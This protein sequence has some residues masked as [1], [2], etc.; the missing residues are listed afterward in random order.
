MGHLENTKEWVVVGRFGRPH[1]LKGNISVYS[2]TQPES[3]ILSYPNWIVMIKG[4]ATPLK[5]LNSE[6][7]PRFLTVALDGFN[8]RD[9]VSQLTNLNI[10]I[11]REDL[12]PLQSEEYYWHQLIGMSVVNRQGFEFGEVSELIPTGA[13]DVLVV[14]GKKRYLIP[15]R[16]GAVVLKVCMDDKQIIVDWDDEYL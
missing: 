2:F 6:V 15:Y 1:G 16:M 5:V 7:H 9:L 12:P 8:D 11:K 10:A 3:N 14:T 13:N 4:I